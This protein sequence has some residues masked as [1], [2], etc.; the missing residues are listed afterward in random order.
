M[1]SWV[2]LSTSF[3]SINVNALFN[4]AV[5]AA[6]CPCRRRGRRCCRLTKSLIFVFLFL[7]VAAASDIAHMSTSNHLFECVCDVCLCKGDGQCWLANT[8]SFV[9]YTLHRPT[10]DFYAILH[11]P[12]TA[13]QPISQS[14]R[15]VYNM[16][17]WWLK[18]NVNKSD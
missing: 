5:A 16:R 15:F 13:Q 2:S 17:H 6:I 7:C 4:A 11:A 12:V 8:T 3:L 9:F 18:C 14:I 10:I 1:T